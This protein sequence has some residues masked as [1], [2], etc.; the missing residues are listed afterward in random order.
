MSFN[1]VQGPPG[2]GHTSALFG[3][4]KGHQMNDPDLKALY[5]NT[6]FS[7][8]KRFI[9]G[10]QIDVNRVVFFTLNELPLIEETIRQGRRIGVK[11]ILIDSLSGIHV[12]EGADVRNEA[13]FKGLSE[14]H[15]FRPRIQQAA[16]YAKIWASIKTRGD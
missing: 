3:V 10:F 16:G 15:S 14:Y 7:D 1:I 12:S 5:F 8:F 2:R 11:L 9:D 13:F 4:L 6:E